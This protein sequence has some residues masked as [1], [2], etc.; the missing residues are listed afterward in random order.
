VLAVGSGHAD[1]EDQPDREGRAGGRLPAPGS[2]DVPTGRLGPLPLL[3]IVS[4]LYSAGPLAT[5]SLVSSSF[6]LWFFLPGCAYGTV[7]RLN[8]DSRPT[9][10]SGCLSSIFFGLL[11]N[12]PTAP[13]PRSRSRISSTAGAG[14]APRSW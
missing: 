7:R 9:P 5:S 14:I 13:S 2:L 1:G 4:V 8:M 12:L 11:A 6:L 10:A 3:A